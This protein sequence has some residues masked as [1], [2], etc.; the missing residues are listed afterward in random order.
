MED[1][2]NNYN[3]EHQHNVF[4][5]VEMF[6]EKFDGVSR[7]EWQKPEEVMASFNVSDDFLVVELGSGTGYFSVR[8][9]PYLKKGKIICLDQSLQMTSYLKKRAVDLGLTNLYARAISS[10]GSIDIEEKADLIFSVDVYHHIKD[11]I[12]YFSKIARYLKPDGRFI[13]IDRTEDKIKDQPTGHRVSK[14]Q[15]KEEMKSIGLE[16]VE[17]LDFLLPIQYHL[18]FK[19]L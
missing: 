19:I 17:D 1:I 13:I 18:T 11:R 8:L 12:S 4:D 9:A 5:S 2:K 6:V 3:H 15:V 10:D 14:E 16:L 7:D